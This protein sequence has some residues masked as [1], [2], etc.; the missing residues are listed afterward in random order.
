MGRIF[1]KKIT[2]P[3]DLIIQSINN[4]DRLNETD[5]EV[6][7]QGIFLNVFDNLKAL[8]SRLQQAKTR[9]R[10]FE[11][12]RNEWIA[13]ISHDL[14]TPLSSISGYSEIMADEKYDLSAEETIKYAEIIK[15][16]AKNIE[17]M[18]SDLSLE[19]K[20]KS[21]EDVL[22]KQK[23]KLNSFL[24]DLIILILNNCQ[25]A[26]RDVTFEDDGEYYLE[27]DKDLFARAI[28]NLITNALKH[29]ADKTIVSVTLK[30][31]PNNQIRISIIDNG[32]GIAKDTLDK[33]FIRYY[34]GEDTKEGVGT[35]LGMSIAKNIIEAHGGKITVLSKE[36]QGTTIKIDI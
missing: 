4:L 9:E 14:K 28:T 3:I 17:N 5:M 30:K 18:I 25:Y 36:N 10:E 6:K 12:Q 20:I 23:V 24:K 8:Q 7:N 26:S 19:L 27:I 29:S 32:K 2:G 16:Q 31:L 33:L 34:I 15:K 1:S 13:N 35:G 11:K 21:V 22:K